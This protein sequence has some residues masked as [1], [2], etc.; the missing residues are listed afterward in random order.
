MVAPTANDLVQGRFGASVGWY[1]DPVLA[2]VSLTYVNDFAREDTVVPG[3]GVQ[4]ANDRDG[5]VLEGSLTL[6]GSG[7]AQGVTASL[8]ASTEIGRRQM[9]SHTVGLNVRADF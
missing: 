7:A 2:G 8:T 5:F 1:V 3:G 4:P 6:Y 9:E